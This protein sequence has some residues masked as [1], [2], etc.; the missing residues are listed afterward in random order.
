MNKV[1]VITGGN[2]GIGKQTAELFQKQNDVV[3]VVSKNVTPSETDYECDVSNF[4]QVKQVFFQIGEKFGRID[5]LINNAGYGIS[6][7]AELLPNE[8][9]SN[10]FE[11]NVMGVVNCSQAA[12]PFMQKGGRI[13]NLSSAMAFFP[14]PFRTMYAASKMAVATLSQGMAMELKQGGIGVCAICPG[15]TKTNFTKNRV[16]HFETN[17]RYGNRISNA[18]SG[19]DG[20]EEKRMNPIVVANAIVGQANRSRMRPVVIVGTK[21]K[22]LYHVAKLF[23]LRLRL[24]LTEKL[25][26]G[27]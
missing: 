18:A 4:E 9:I 25:F 13:L 24:F 11:V 16:K 12:L 17:E 15:D 2:S 5:V 10:L 21:Y 23:P 1:V 6:G 27:Y 7:A 19:L 3:V 20:K 8:A 26:G 22:V 14:L